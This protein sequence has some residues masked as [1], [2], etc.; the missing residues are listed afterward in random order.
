[1]KTRG[2]AGW[3]HR[4]PDLTDRPSGA[5]KRHDEFHSDDSTRRRDSR[6]GG[7]PVTLPARAAAPVPARQM[8]LTLDAAAPTRTTRTLLPGVVHVPDWLTPAAQYEIA[9]EFRSWAL[10]PAGLR[11]P[12]VPTGHLMSVQSVCLGWHWHPYAY[13]S[14][15]D[16]TDG[17]P[18]K[19]MPASVDTLARGPSPTPTGPTA[20]GGAFAARRCDRQPLPAPVPGSACTRTARSRRARRS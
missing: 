5:L 19:P 3:Q 14:T 17:A 10:P 20:R 12:R 6:H 2:A 7:V 11:H 15:A 18:V 1:M 9:E 13:C 16:D 8:A 4:R